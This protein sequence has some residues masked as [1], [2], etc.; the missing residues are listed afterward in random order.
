MSTLDTIDPKKLGDRLRAARASARKTQEQAAAAI[1]IARPTL[2]TIEKGDRPVRMNELAALAEFYG[3]STN[4]LLHEDRPI[5]EFSPQFRRTMGKETDEAASIQ[6]VRLLE[7]LAAAYATL[8]RML[9]QT[10]TA[11]YPAPVKLIRG[12]VNEQAE[13]MA[14]TTRTW[15]GI[16]LS[17]I[18]DLGALLDV[19]WHF[20][21]FVR[22]LA[23]R[24]S[25]VYAFSDELG[26][27]VLLNAKHPF[28]R[29]QNTLAHELGHF[30]STRESVEVAV[31][32]SEA[33]DSPSEKF[34]SRF[35]PAFLM[36]GPALRRRYNE[37]TASQPFS[38]RHLIFL[39]HA[40]HVSNEGMCRRLESLRLVHAGTW[41]MLRER[42][43]G[44]EHVR[45]VLPTQ[46]EPVYV[47][48]PTRLDLMVAEAYT[49][50]L[51][52]EGQLASMLDLD[53]IAVRELLDRLAPVGEE[54]F[55][56]P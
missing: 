45:Q 16:G 35:G 12:Q 2:V 56:V 5:A 3:T 4:T 44:E 20:R 34:A 42:G 28:P 38:V 31:F 47:E 25:G 14:L 39:A 7:R 13:D 48:G 11:S 6:A 15:L 40:F 1:G 46:E 51:A 21:I 19:E 22:P 33:E 53:R 37:I 24:I 41:D 27:C 43:F 18:P 26:P 50:Q 9:G 23:S 10:P 29:R 30:V 54:G 17:P 32:D 52:S 49:R 55:D 36:P 8:A